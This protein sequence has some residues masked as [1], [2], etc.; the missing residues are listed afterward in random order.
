MGEGINKDTEAY[1]EWADGTIAQYQQVLT[2]NAQPNTVYTTNTSTGFWPPHHA[3]IYRSDD[4]GGNWWDTFFP[5]PRG[6]PYNVT[7]NWL[8]ATLGQNW[9]GAPYG[10]A[11]CDS[12][13]NRIIIRQHKRLRHPRRRPE[14]FSA[15]HLPDGAGRTASGTTAAWW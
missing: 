8:T 7:P 3:T 2:T 15:P 4:A 11:I 13:P 1:D 10:A 6:D 5:D 14:R 9:P 12:D